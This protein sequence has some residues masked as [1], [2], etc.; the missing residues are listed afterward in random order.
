MGLLM[1]IAFALV[2]HRHFQAVSAELGRLSD[3]ELD[4]RGL[5][6]HGIPWAA[7]EESE[8]RAEATLAGLGWRLARSGRHVADADVGGLA[9]P[10]A[11]SRT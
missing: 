1:Q 5:T 10:G 2:Q 11:R 7:F 4:Q 6:R 3:H 8:R 9:G